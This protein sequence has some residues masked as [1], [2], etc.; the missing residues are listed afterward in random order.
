MVMLETAFLIARIPVFR[1]GH[2]TSD[3]FRFIGGILEQQWG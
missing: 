1:F 2:S 3:H